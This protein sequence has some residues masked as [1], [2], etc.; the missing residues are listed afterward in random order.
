MKTKG[1]VAVISLLLVP[2]LAPAGDWA[3]LQAG[4]AH[5]TIEAAGSPGSG[6]NSVIQLFR[7]D[8][9]K[10][11]LRPIV[12]ATGSTL[13]AG[14]ARRQSGALLTINANFFDEANNILGLVI[15]NGKTLSPIRKV[16]WW[17]VFFQKGSDVGIVHSSSYATESQIS[18]AIE[19]G[20]RLVVDGV[21]PRLKTSFSRKS[22]IGIN[23]RGDVLVAVS[24]SPIEAARFAEILSLP[25]RKG[26]G[27]C[28]Q[29]LN[30]DGGGSTQLSAESSDFKLNVAGFSGVP[31]LLG[32]F[33]K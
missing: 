25:E 20:P 33:G 17:A 21:L 2:H 5:R 6:K 11:H 28:L 7:I 8:P 32:V 27:G 9:K 16:S 18:N 31:V 30:L 3:T 10:Y 15:K 24:S 22:A 26:G 12:A 19:A 23:R 13:S 4:F 14:D 29:A 1:I